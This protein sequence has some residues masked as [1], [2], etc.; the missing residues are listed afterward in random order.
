LNTLGQLLREHR[1]SKGLLLRQ[2]AASLELDTALLSK[3]ERNERKPN[4]E[5]VLAFAKFYAVN[6]EQLY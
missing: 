5:Q 3:F 6:S 4:K 1:E 2:V